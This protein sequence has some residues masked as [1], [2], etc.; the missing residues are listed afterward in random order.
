MQNSNGFWDYSELLKKIIS[1]PEKEVI[2]NNIPKDFLNNE[3]SLKIFITIIALIY[4]TKNY[5]DK[6]GVW[7]LVYRKGKNWLKKEKI[8]LNLY[9]QEAMKYL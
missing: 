9:E 4:L 6:Q 8:D 5:S 1:L 3:N 2:I 7:N